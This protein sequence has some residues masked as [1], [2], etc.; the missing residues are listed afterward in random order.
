M[1]KTILKINSSDFGIIASQILNDGRSLKFIATGQS[2]HPSI[3]NGDLITVIPINGI[4]LRCGD[5]ILYLTN[6]THSPIAHRILSIKTTKTGKMLY[7]RGDALGGHRECI[8]PKNILGK[9]VK[10]ERNGHTIIID[11]P[12]SRLKGR[13]RGIIQSLRHKYFNILRSKTRH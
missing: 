1:D 13:M 10:L 9:A 6:E 4:N 11:T 12:A 5:V 3:H 8:T 7:V 2:M